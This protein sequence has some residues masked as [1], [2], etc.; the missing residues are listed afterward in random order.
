MVRLNSVEGCL[1][2]KSMKEPDHGPPTLL[3][4]EF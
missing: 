3:K 1:S 2:Y 4:K